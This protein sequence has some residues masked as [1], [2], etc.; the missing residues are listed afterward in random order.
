MSAP[1]EQ[2]RVTRATDLDKFVSNI[3]QR[4]K[5]SS[6]LAI[7]DNLVNNPYLQNQGEKSKVSNVLGVKLS[8][9]NKI[10]TEN[11]KK[12]FKKFLDNSEE[13][14]T[15]LSR[16]S[17]NVSKV[18]SQQRAALKEYQKRVSRGNRTI[19]INVDGFTI[20]PDPKKVARTRH[21]Y[22]VGSFPK[23]LDL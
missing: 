10:T 15:E 19:V 8:S 16:I 9:T 5:H 22:L 1:V 14:K 20:E 6:G 17:Q 7:H 23:S 13:R 11:S 18:N 12:T 4:I 2:I 21:L 3:N